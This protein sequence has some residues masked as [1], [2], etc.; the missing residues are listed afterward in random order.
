MPPAVTVL[1]P[2]YNADRFVA[3]TVET[4]LAQ[5]F[6]D[7]EFLII[8]DGSTDRSL[9]ILQGY[10]NRD[11]RIRLVSRPNTGYVAALNEGLGLNRSEFLARIDADDLTDPRRLELQVARMR[12]EPD[13][14]ALG[15]CALAIDEDGL[16]LGDYSVPL[17]HEEIE[18]HH[19]RGSSAIHHPAV[20]LRP[21][22]VKRVGG[23]RRELMPCED[24]DLWLRLGEVGRVANLP[25]TLLTKR[26]FAGSA[27]ASNLEKQ[28]K[29]V[30]QILDET[31]LRRGLGG[32]PTMP[33][34]RL[35]DRADLFRQWGWM[36]LRGGHLRSS[37]RYAL[38][39][40]VSRPLDKGSWRLAFCSLRGR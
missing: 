3:E 35:R 4:I 20:M 23:Y 28:E 18:A 27:V 16:P 8:N 32:R 14:V 21:E 11:P 7:F 36:A 12:G 38:R 34:R 1:M 5:T 31:W 17:T 6:R 2:V 9:E 10:A 29:L 30:K 37:R 24:F 13:L 39:A 40:I 25:E 22:A 15:S 33:P 19:L 26:L